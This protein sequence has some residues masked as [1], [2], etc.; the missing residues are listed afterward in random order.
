MMETEWKYAVRHEA[1]KEV[2]LSGHI[3][4]TYRTQ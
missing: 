4:T 1:V 2:V 3:V